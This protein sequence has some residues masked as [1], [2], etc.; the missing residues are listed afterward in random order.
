V[1][2]FMP[3][4][5]TCILLF[6]YVFLFSLLTPRYVS[7][8]QMHLPF[9]EVA[10]TADLIFVGT[11]VQE[12]CR[13]NQQQSMIFTD[14]LFEDISIVHA[15]GSSVQRGSETIRL[16]FAGGSLDGRRVEISDTPKLRM[17]HRYLIFALDD[18]KIYLSP[19]VGGTQ[20]L[21]EVVEDAETGEFRILTFG[22]K[23]VLGFDAEGPM[24]GSDRVLEIRGGV[25]IA[26]P[27]QEEALAGLPSSDDPN[28]SVRASRRESSR[29]SPITLEE[30]TRYV[31]DEALTVPLSNRLLRFEGQGLFYRKNDDG[32][33]EAENLKLTDPSR[34][35]R[36]DQ[37]DPHKSP[38]HPL[39][40]EA[41]D[42][43]ESSR[44][45]GGERSTGAKG[46][47]LGACGFQYLNI[48]M[49]QVPG[50]NWVWHDNDNAMWIWN[51]FMDVYRYVGTDGD[52]GYW[53]DESEFCGWVDDATAYDI[54]GF[55]WGSYIGMCVNCGYTCECCEIWESDVLLNAGRVWTNDPDISIGD[56]S[57]VLA[58]PVIMHEVGHTWGYQCG[59]YDET[60]DYDRPSVMHS[61][62]WNIVED[63][64]GIHR[65]DAYI[66]R[67]HYSD[68]TPINFAIL[69][70]G[71]ESYWADDGLH[72]SYTDAPSYCHYDNITLNN[73]TVENNSFLGLSDV[74]IRF[75]LSENDYISTSDYQ[76]GTYWSW[77][78][79]APE[80]YGVYDFTVG[81]PPEVPPGEYYVGAILTYNG[82]ESDTYPHNNVTRLFS[83][84]WVEDS[85]VCQVNPT[86]LDFGTVCV[87]DYED[88]SFTITNIGVCLL[89]GEVIEV[90]PHYSIISGGG[91]YSL[92]PGQTKTVTVR[93]QPTSAG[94][95]DGVIGTDAGC[96]QVT[97]TG[98]GSA[99]AIA[100]T[101]PNGGENWC[102]GMSYQITWNSPCIAGLVTIQYS[103]RGGL[104]WET[105]TS[106]TTDDGSYSWLVPETPSTLCKV[107]VISN[108]DPSVYDMSNANFT[109]REKEMLLNSPNG[110]ETWSVGSSY[111]II[112]DSWCLNGP[113]KLEYS[114]SGGLTWKTIDSSTTDDGIY[115]WTVPNTPTTIGRVKVTSIWY[116]SI[117]DRSDGTFTIT[118]EA[119]AV[120]SPDGG[121]G[122]CIDSTYAVSWSSS[123]IDNVRIEYSSDGCSSWSTI[124]A[125]V[126]AD[127]GTYDWIVP[128]TPSQNCKVR[129]CD[130][131]D[132][133]PCDESDRMFTI[134][135]GSQSFFYGDANGDGIIDLGDAVYILNY[136]FKGDDP[137][138]PL[139]A[140]D[141]NCDGI[142]NL[143]DAIYL[144][145][146]LFKGGNPPGCP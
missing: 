108:S 10:Q 131:A 24:V 120:S 59:I 61:Y 125:S 39:T 15:K 106:S 118:A 6:W 7:G 11:A 19:I 75:Y 1:E 26:A 133:V 54:W 136:L 23:P 53:N 92:G 98:V 58:L 111:D 4:R 65:T 9:A 27:K 20:G 50:S 40:P 123:W 44:G 71:V 124:A 102:E 103:T 88:R 87:G 66:F 100:V 64:L 128:P 105:I 42:N 73:I 84:I 77:A 114:T 74:R 82:Y 115:T 69:D 18:G 25:I 141:A 119:V 21:F 96:T 48:V 95:K 143:G 93:F 22:H 63:G 126:P 8:I 34:L 30:F 81:L 3:K 51:Q 2:V 117:Y 107:K 135:D 5:Y 32:G 85:P 13:I 137:P 94:T 145:N 37:L 70:V 41:D 49:E 86:S 140:G 56:P 45:Q 68:Q 80:T 17:G 38:L 67:R 36:L 116:P 142:V 112:W 33:V 76:I 113:V 31:R 134:W 90:W 101:S 43:F 47:D 57:I 72:N 60:Y 29:G 129:I 89:T 12:S 146:Y 127:P 78:T 99:P 130:A 122:W 109:I 132:N 28:S 138:D 104:D 14:V 110:G 35:P 139:E 52:I 97:C 46:G 55:H 83:T 144:L 62:Y 79:F 91:A 16:T 121:E